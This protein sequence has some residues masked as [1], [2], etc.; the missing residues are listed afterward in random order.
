M[1]HRSA[2]VLLYVMHDETE[3]FG[4]RESAAAILPMRTELR[5]AHKD[6]RINSRV[7]KHCWAIIVAVKERKVHLSLTAMEQKVAPHST[8]ELKTTAK[9]NNRVQPDDGSE[10]GASSTPKAS[11]KPRTSSTLSS[12][13]R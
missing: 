2:G 11:K 6:V 9:R 3:E 10:G 1:R 5:Q 12:T 13:Q 8:V 7:C 4:K